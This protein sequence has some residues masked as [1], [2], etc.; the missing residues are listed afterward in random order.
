M[1][2]A[3]RSASENQRFSFGVAADS[4]AGGLAGGT[5]G[6]DGFKVGHRAH[7]PTRKLLD[8]VANDDASP[9]AWRALAYSADEC[10]WPV[11]GVSHPQ[12]E[13]RRPPMARCHALQARQIEADDR[14]L[15][16]GNYRHAHLT[17]TLH[18]FL[19]RR[20]VHGHVADVKVDALLAKEL[21]R[22]DTP[23]S[24]RGGVNRNP[25]AGLNCHEDIIPYSRGQPRHFH[26][27][28]RPLL[29]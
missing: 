12:S 22:P 25:S 16:V 29:Q 15:F 21:L 9:F 26:R 1:P 18:H 3:L 17:G 8:H 11:F 20:A 14:F 2:A 27:M 13:T 10:T 23:G 24:G 28:R 7:R 19:S 4:Q 5:P 6:G